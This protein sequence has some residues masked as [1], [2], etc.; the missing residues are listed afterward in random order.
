MSVAL[1]IQHEML[2]RRIVHLWFAPLYHTFPRYLIK[3]TIFGK[4][5]L[6]I[7]CVF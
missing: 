2:M 7:K 6:N 4:K 3:G 1:V 5:S